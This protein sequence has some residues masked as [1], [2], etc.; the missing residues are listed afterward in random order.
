[1]ESVAQ[2]LDRFIKL[3]TMAFLG[4]STGETVSTSVTVNKL[5][6]KAAKSVYPATYF[7]GVGDD[8][9]VHIVTSAA[10]KK[11]LSQATYFGPQKSAIAETLI[12]PDNSRVSISRRSDIPEVSFDEVTLRWTEPTID[13][14]ELHPAVEV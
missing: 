10:M 11:S 9:T 2:G 12:L 4:Q 1:M 13:I 7:A 3:S 5:T 8:E 14:L 6:V